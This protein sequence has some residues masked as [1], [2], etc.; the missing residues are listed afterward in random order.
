MVP[1]GRS[2]HVL[3]VPVCHCLVPSVP[4]GCAPR[5]CPPELFAETSHRF[6][7][8]TAI[9]AFSG[10]LPHLEQ[11]LLLGLK[12]NVTKT[13]LSSVPSAVGVVMLGDS[14]C[15]CWEVHLLLPLPCCN[16]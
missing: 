12:A 10:E 11:L 7:V 4:H 13:P 8:I 6:T 1:V 15:C 3:I 5:L 9:F 16:P 14:L 2:H